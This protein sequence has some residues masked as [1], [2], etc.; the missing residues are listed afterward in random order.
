MYITYEEFTA[1]YGT[2]ALTRAEF[3]LYE[4][5]AESV[6]DNYTTGI[7]GV[8]KLG[9]AFPTG[10]DAE[11]VKRC[12]AKLTLTLCSITKASMSAL[13]GESGA[14][15]KSVS[16]GSESVT[17]YESDL[18]KATG[19]FGAR[20]KMMRDICTSMLRGRNDANG[21][22]LLYLGRYPYV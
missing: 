10:D 11:A 21:V 8:R 14:M 2:D 5:D 18:V 9:V 3:N 7:D 4:Y 15:V 6:V 19:D 16:S 22:N 13:T 17:Y 12:V 1:L 20:A